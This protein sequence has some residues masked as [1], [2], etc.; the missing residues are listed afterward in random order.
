MYYKIL[1]GLAYS[2]KLTALNTFV[3]ATDLSPSPGSDL[4]GSSWTTSFGLLFFLGLKFPHRP[5]LKINV[6]LVCA[7]KVLRTRSEASI[8]LARRLKEG[9]AVTSWT[10]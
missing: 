7:S 5:L 2:S 1:T 9:H 4:T 10:L 3:V 6:D 8:L